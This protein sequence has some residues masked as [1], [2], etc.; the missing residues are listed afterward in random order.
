MRRRH[1][2]ALL[3][4][5]SAP[6]AG[7]ADAAADSRPGRIERLNLASRHVAERPVDV[8][9]PPGYRA[10]RPHAVL[11]M[12]D[13]QMLFDPA[14]TW[15]RQAWQVD[16]VVAPLIAAG[17]LRDFIVVGIWNTGAARAA[18]Y[19]PQGFVPHV[20]APL[21]ERLLQE[22]LQ[23]RPRA[24]A[25]LRFLVEELKPQVDVRYATAPGRASTFLMGSSMGGLISCYGLC[26]YP[27]V[28]G[29]AACLSTHWI[30]LF[31]RNDAIPA[32]ALAY[33]RTRLPAPDTVKLYMDRGDTE[34]DALYDTAQARVDALMAERGFGAPGFVSQVF[35][36]HGHNE[37]DWSRRLALPLQFLLGV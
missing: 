14:R 35:A 10:D 6:G 28:F 29:G 15:N 9:L 18:E 12:H 13:G 30:G 4:L 1:L 34:L 21:R 20:A 23:N 32:A 37:T 36:G 26:E 5:P 19:F 22:R 24:D 16:A 11:Y 2:L 17:T 8:W 25:Y 7:A 33:L 31:E 27:Q 3:G